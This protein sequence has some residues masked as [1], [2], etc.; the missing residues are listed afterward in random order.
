[1]N[2]EDVQFQIESAGNGVQVDTVPRKLRPNVVLGPPARQEWYMRRQLLNERGEGRLL[3]V[4]R[5]G[6]AELGQRSARL[7]FPVLAHGDEIGRVEEEPEHVTA[8]GR[9]SVEIAKE[10]CRG[11]VPDQDVPARADDEGRHR[12]QAL[13]ESLERDEALSCWGWGWRDLASQG[14]QILALD[15]LKLECIGE[16]VQDDGGDAALAAL[17]QPR[18]PRFADAGELG[19]LLAAETVQSLAPPGCEANSLGRRAL[20]AE[21]KELR[22]GAEPDTIVDHEHHPQ[23][24]R[25]PDDVHT[26]KQ[27]A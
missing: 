23:H 2:A 5:P 14:K 19:D 25:E 17:L 1:M 16:T 10:H 21:T 13:N 27:A 22:N 3:Q 20:A 6:E 12:L 7:T 24:R 26:D 8:L 4:S 15:R 18:V 9:P 11:A